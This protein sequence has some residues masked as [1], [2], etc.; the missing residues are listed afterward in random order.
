MWK[1]DESEKGKISPVE[2]QSSKLR[3]DGDC[4]HIPKAELNHGST[5]SEG[6]NCL[7]SFLYNFSSMENF[8]HCFEMTS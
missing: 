5:G 6:F 7:K 3:L 4:S 8:I 1:K 2:N